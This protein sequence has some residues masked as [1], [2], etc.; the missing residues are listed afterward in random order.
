[1]QTREE[2]VESNMRTLQTQTHIRE[3]K[4]FRAGGADATRRAR[5][6][7]GDKVLSG[8]AFQRRVL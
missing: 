1:M 4:A 5:G 6:G 3:Q 8:E 2:V 7:D